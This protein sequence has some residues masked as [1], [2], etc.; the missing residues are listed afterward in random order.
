MKCQTLLSAY[1][2]FESV[3]RCLHSICC[4][5]RESPFYANYVIIKKWDKSDFL[6]KISK[7]LEMK[8]GFIDIFWRISG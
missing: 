6:E 7:F 5:G 3:W 8:L 2:H 4:T 1:F